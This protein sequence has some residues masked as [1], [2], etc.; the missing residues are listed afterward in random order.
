MQLKG[1][2]AGSRI[3]LTGKVA[4]VTGASRGIG[5]AVA[6]MLGERGVDVIVNYRSKPKRA[7]R[8]AEA[9][10]T[11]GRRALGAQADLT[12]PAEMKTMMS[13]IHE[14]FGRLDILILNASG[15]L[16]KDKP[17]DYAMELN[18]DAQARAVDLALPLMPSGGRILFVTSHLAHFY[19]SKPVLSVY[20][21]VAV[22]KKAGEDTLRSRLP[23]FATKGISLVVVSGDLIEGTITPKLMERQ[24]PGLLESRRQ[25]AGALP[26]TQ[27]FAAAIVDAAANPDLV[28]GVTIF[29]GHTE[30]YR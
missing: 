24:R 12:S 4:L 11:A 6:R 17:A 20:E 28:S 16:E 22:S 2:Q 15:G 21:P 19:G 1:A 13:V 27:E 10:R 18:C 25:Q 29:V 7:E 9:I 8:V 26:T 23:E 30:W 3:A 14:Q 5:A